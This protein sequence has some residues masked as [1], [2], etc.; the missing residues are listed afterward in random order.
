MGCV[1]WTMLS[2]SR[3][4]FAQRLLIHIFSRVRPISVSCTDCPFPL[5]QPK[6]RGGGNDDNKAEEGE[7]GKHCLSLN[8]EPGTGLGGIVAIAET[9]FGLHTHERLPHSVFPTARAISLRSEGTLEEDC[10]WRFLEAENGKPPKERRERAKR[11]EE[12]LEY[13][14][15]KRERTFP[16]T[17]N[18][19][20]ARRSKEEGCDAGTGK[21]VR[22]STR[23]TEVKKRK[24]R[25]RV[26]I[27][28]R[29]RFL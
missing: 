19:G 12:D 14:G 17:A 26:R 20:T 8:D 22:K 4:M 24:V 16:P 21:D 13:M 2:D 18:R 7:K 10:Q 11:I 5:L 3:K 27:C 15:W 23:K 9:M 1:L 25:F 28:I 29:I 6:Q